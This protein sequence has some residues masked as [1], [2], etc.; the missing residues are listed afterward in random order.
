MLEQ[1]KGETISDLYA[2]EIN[3][4]IMAKMSTDAEK[5]KFLVDSVAG[6]CEFVN[7][8]NNEFSS[9]PK[10]THP[11]S[12]L[13][14]GGIFGANSSIRAVLGCQGDSKKF[15]TC[16]IDSKEIPTYQSDWDGDEG[17]LTEESP[18]TQKNKLKGAGKN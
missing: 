8:E 5:I 12:A 3:A 18:D 2:A 9:D 13:R 16:G 10:K 1:Q 4:A 6:Y 11:A 17:V 15:K 14:I 7:G